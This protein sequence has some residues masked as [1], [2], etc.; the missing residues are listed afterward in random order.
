MRETTP[1]ALADLPDGHAIGDPAVLD[2][3][4]E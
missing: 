4:G 3:G 1:T 2:L